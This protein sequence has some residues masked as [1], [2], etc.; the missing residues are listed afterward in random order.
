MTDIT[1]LFLYLSLGLIILWTVRL[2]RSKGRNPFVW[3][4]IALLL[5]LI[6]SWPDLLGMGPMM[7]LLFLKSPQPASRET[8]PETVTCPKCH[9]YHAIGHTYCV[10]C[11]WELGRDFNGSPRQRTEAVTAVAHSE[12][13]PASKSD[14]IG[15]LVK[16]PPR[17]FASE[18]ASPVF[19]PPVRPADSEPDS[20]MVSEEIA[21][22]EV[23]VPE[24]VSEAVPM[25]SILEP[26]PKVQQPRY[27]ITPAGFT[28]RGSALVAEG[29]FQVAIDQFTKAIALNPAY[30]PAWTRRA[31]AYDLMGRQDKA[32]EDRRHLDGLPEQSAG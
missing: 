30:R 9:A 4:G 21:V 17:H 11:G 19:V 10:N 24:A 12:P 20:A 8:V 22:P 31:E 25:E 16:P 27:P 26:E 23:A 3:G 28:E 1:N 32:R 15:P 13:E 18:G 6:P 5:M 2:A 7:I 29:N 14:Q